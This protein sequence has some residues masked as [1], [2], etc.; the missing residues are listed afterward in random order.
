MAEENKQDNLSSSDRDREQRRVQEQAQREERRAKEQAQREERKAKEAA[1][2]NTKMTKGAIEKQ[3]ARAAAK[4]YGIDTK[5]MSTREI[6]AA[7]SEA[8]AIQ[9]Q[10]ENDMS[11]F[12]EKTLDNF[13]SKKGGDVAPSSVPPSVTNRILEDKPIFMSGASA[14]SRQQLNYRLPDPPSGNKLHVLGVISGVLEW[15]E[16]ESCE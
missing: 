3:E 2:R 8:G 10:L 15:I 9:K 7:V 14:P 12:I 16:T 4:E 1:A 6:R 13:I 5:G 11:K